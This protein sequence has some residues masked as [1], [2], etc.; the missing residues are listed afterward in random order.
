MKNKNDTHRFVHQWTFGSVIR[1]KVP[2]SKG[3]YHGSCMAIRD[4]DTGSIAF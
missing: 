4:N 3:K 1:E 2:K